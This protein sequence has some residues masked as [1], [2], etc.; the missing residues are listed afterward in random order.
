MPWQVDG[1]QRRLKGL[2]AAEERAQALQNQVLQERHALQECQLALQQ[3]QEVSRPQCQVFIV[4]YPAG[5]LTR[6][7]L[8]N[9]TLLIV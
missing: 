7:F 4:S 2:E 8:G 9:L 6:P 5:M 3:A 1:F